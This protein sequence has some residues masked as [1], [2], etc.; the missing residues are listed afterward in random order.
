MSHSMDRSAHRGAPLST[1]PDVRVTYQ[2]V[3]LVKA[4]KDKV[5]SDLPGIEKHADYSI[6]MFGF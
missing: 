6:L 2:A 5:P 4:G 3:R 1:P